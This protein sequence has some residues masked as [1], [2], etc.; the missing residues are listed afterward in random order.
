MVSGRYW[1]HL[2]QEQPA[3]EAADPKFQDPAHRQLK[4]T[5]GCWASGDLIVT[6]SQMVKYL[7]NLA[8]LGCCRNSESDAAVEG[9]PRVIASLGVRFERHF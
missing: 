7:K 6:L 2:R 8:S 4:R 1:H 9:E 5:D 3:N